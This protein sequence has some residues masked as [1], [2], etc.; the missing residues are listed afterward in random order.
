MSL[1]RRNLLGIGSAGLAVAASTA[2]GGQSQANPKTAA[3]KQDPIKSNTIVDVVVIGAGVS[4]LI[5]ARDLERQGRSTTVL[6]AAP[7]LGGRCIRKQTIQNWWLDLGGQWM[8]KTH[9]LF[10][11]LAKELNI[12]TFDSYFDGKTVLVWNG[13]RVAVPM[14]GDWAE[15]FLDVAYD[16]VP[17]APQ[18]RDAARKLHRE[19]LELVQTVDADRPWLTPRARA[20]DTQTIETW[21]RQRTD[22]DLAHAIMRWYARV[23]GSGGFE[24][25]DASILHLAQTQKASPQA[26]T[27][28]AWLLY[29]A[30]G[31]IPERLA[32][33][34]KGQIRTNAA[35]RL[36]RRLNNG[37]YVVSA[38]D[39]TTHSCRAVVVAMPPALR[40]RIVFDPGLPPD[41][42]RLCQRAPMGSM[43][44]VLTVYTTA[45]WRDQGLNGY[46][47]GNLPT[48]ELTADSSPPSG[49]P[50]VLASFVSADRAISL[51]YNNAERRRQAILSDLATYWGPRAAEPVDYIEKNWNE[52]NWVTGAFSSYMTPGTWTSVGQAWQEPVGNVV[53]AGT[54]SSARWAGYY[55][56]AI[57]AGMDAARKVNDLITS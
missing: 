16:D 25:G 12:E 32:A 45:W 33:Q 2:V 56:G 52:E 10:K 40:T 8:G 14:N 1:S 34:L 15:T 23:G 30:A 35:A 53:W 9:H 38:A 7:R 4:G 41:V 48:I 46:G 28:E 55:E 21:M 3:T 51:G 36:V 44:K 49:K 29:G 54:E 37:R 39:G 43:F 18:D 5:S 20:L 50:G 6:E 27:P 11:A 57:Q 42:T 26:E 19:F 22:S 31:Q 13:K 47:Q 17:V 24:T